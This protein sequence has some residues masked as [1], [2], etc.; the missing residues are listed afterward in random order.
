M[1]QF[2]QFSVATPL[3]AA[4]ADFMA[5]VPGHTLELARFYQRKRDHFCGLLAQT[6]FRCSPSAGTYFQLAD[7][8]AL[9]DEPDVEIR[10][11]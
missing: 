5:E 1:H 6:R 10:A 2:V 9:S 3:Q 7:Y 11:G 4:F 8:S